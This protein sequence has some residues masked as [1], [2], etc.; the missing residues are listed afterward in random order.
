M[1]TNGG[2]RVTQAL[3]QTLLRNCRGGPIQVPMLYQHL[4]VMPQ[5]PGN[6]RSRYRSEQSN[7]SGVI[8]SLMLFLLPSGVRV[9]SSVLILF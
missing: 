6:T 9:G 3:L 2:T 4:Y 1:C 8:R 5:Q 7:F